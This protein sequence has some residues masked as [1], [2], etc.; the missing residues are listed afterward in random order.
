M[1]PT[2]LQDFPGHQHAVL[3]EDGFGER[4]VALLKAGARVSPN[5]HTARPEPGAPRHSMASKHELSAEMSPEH[6]RALVR[7]VIGIGVNIREMAD[8][9]LS[10]AVKGLH[11]CWPGLA[12][13]FAK[14]PKK[15]LSD[16]PKTCID[17][18]SA[19][20]L[21]DSIK[22]SVVRVKAHIKEVESHHD[23]LV[24][25]P[26]WPGGHPTYAMLAL[27]G[28]STAKV[29]HVFELMSADGDDDHVCLVQSLQ[30]SCIACFRSVWEQ[31]CEPK[32]RALRV[33]H[34]GVHGQVTGGALWVFPFYNQWQHQLFVLCTPVSFGKHCIWG[35]RRR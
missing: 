6:Q 15:A 27:I 35:P 18:G 33:A 16:A 8:P 11:D 9:V 12:E 24:R 23:D 30:A 26:P 22:A 1:P 14:N 25:S 20:E 28:F 17:M 5:V 10:A 19:Y 13:W 31:D 7:G 34:S 21:I 2:V 4:L 3:V 32:C 29:D